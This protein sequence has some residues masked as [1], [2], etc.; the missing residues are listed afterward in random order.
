MKYTVETAP[1]VPAMMTAMQAAGIQ[2]KS[3]H[4]R[5]WNLINDAGEMTSARVTATAPDL[6]KAYVSQMASMGG[7]AT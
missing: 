3:K 6:S 7:L 1:A 4:E 2:P 5:I